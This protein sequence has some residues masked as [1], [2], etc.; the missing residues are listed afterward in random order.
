LTGRSTSDGRGNAYIV[1]LV[2]AEGS[3][4]QVA[5]RL[6]FPNGTAVTPDNST[7]I[8]AESYAEQVTAYDIGDD[9]ALTGR[10]VW[11]PTPGDHPDGFCLDATGAVWYADV[12]NR[13][14]VQVADGGTVLD[15]AELDRGAFAYALSRGDRPT[16]YVVGQE[17]H[18]PDTVGGG[19]G[20][21]VA[22][23]ARAP[24]AGPP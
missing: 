17:F 22:F 14:C 3:V 7:L 10:R 5:D 12:G 20:Q 1:A 11:A 16:L 21:V 19:T 8:V 4:R 24:R 13:H 2:T 15:T 23:P 6:S 9:G 18:G